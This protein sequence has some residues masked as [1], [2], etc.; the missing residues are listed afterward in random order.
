M[1][2]AAMP[3]SWS[4][5]TWSCISAI[6]GEITRCRR[7]AAASAG[8]WKHKRFAAAGGHDREQV[9]AAKDVVHDLL[10]PG[11]KGIEAKSLLELGGEGGGREAGGRRVV[12]RAKHNPASR[13]RGGSNHRV[14]A[15]YP[16]QGVIVTTTR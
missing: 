7:R 13:I 10:L 8:S 15:R 3:L 12:H 2:V 1:N 14:I 4:R 6:S 5:R 11:T 9:A 16:F